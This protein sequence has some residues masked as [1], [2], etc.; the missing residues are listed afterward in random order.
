MTNMKNIALGVLATALVI[1]AATGNRADRRSRVLRALP[2]NPT[3]EPVELLEAVPFVLEES[4]VHT[5]RKDQPSYRAGY[6]IALRA[7]P[8]LIR[9]RQ[10]AEPV[11]YVGEQIAERCNAGTESG[12]LIC[13][14]PAPLRPNGTVDLD[15]DTTAIWFGAPELPERLDAAAIRAAHLN[16]LL[17]GVGPAPLSP[18]LRRAQSAVAPN[19]GVFARDRDELDLS[20]ADLIERYSP[21]ETE[22]VQGMR[23]PLTRR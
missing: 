9:P 14:V 4:F 15:L 17:Q 18:G 10:T 13:L 1:G 3:L 20:I 6:L 22:L 19:A 2:T 8:D 23:V 16:A 21:M 5:W 11:L 7:D 12:S